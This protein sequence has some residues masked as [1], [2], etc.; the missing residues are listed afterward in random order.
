[1]EVQIYMAKI[2]GIYK[3]TNTING[4]TYIGRSVNILKRFSD[5]RYNFKSNAYPSYALYRAMKK[6]GIENFKFEIIEKCDEDELD[7]REIYWIEQYHSFGDGGYNMTAGGNNVPDGFYYNGK[8]EK[9][10]EMLYEIYE[11]SIKKECENGITKYVIDKLGIFDETFDDL[12]FEEAED[13]YDGYDTMINDF[14]GG[15]RDF[16]AW[17]ECNLI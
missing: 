11:N 17:A 8:S 2:C 14:C 4:K 1:M 3:I 12:D 10:Y 13:K 7:D 16:E 6:Y 5:H 9:Y 15:Y